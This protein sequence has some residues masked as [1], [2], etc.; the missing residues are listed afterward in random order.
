MN[1]LS[2]TFSTVKKNHSYHPG[3][4]LSWLIK[5]ALLSI[6]KGRVQSGET[7]GKGK[8]RHI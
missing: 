7:L 3:F 5:Q 4:H 6:C 1:H 2:L 8:D